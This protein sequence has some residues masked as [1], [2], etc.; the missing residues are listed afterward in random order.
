[1]TTFKERRQGLVALARIYVTE[2]STNLSI[3]E[4]QEL[5]VLIQE[6][7][8][9]L[10]ILELLG[11]IT[12]TGKVPVERVRFQDIPKVVPF[13][14]PFHKAE[15]SNHFINQLVSKYIKQLRRVQ[16]VQY[17][18]DYEDEILTTLLRQG[19]EAMF[20]DLPEYVTQ[21]QVRK[22]M[23]SRLLQVIEGTHPRI[24]VTIGPA[25]HQASI[26]TPIRAGKA[27]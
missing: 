16:L 21:G 9:R 10:R 8:D 27:A 18:K 15:D 6:Q 11:Q 1:M 7:R 23:Q 2:F 13:P 14:A 26:R 5:R 24:S 20:F 19:E 25:P 4:L 3:R 17:I 22:R 12:S